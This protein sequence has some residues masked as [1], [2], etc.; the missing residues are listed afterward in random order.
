M[1][2]IRSMNVMSEPNIL[3]MRSLNHLKKILHVHSTV[4][5]LRKSLMDIKFKN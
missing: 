5:Y 3:L 1:L 4:K 2:E